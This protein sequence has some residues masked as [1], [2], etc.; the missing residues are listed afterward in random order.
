MITCSVYGSCR[1]SFAVGIRPPSTRSSSSCRRSVT[2]GF[3]ASAYQANVTVRAVVSCPA[4]NVVIDSSRS[5]LSDIAW[6]VSSSRA[7]ISRERRSSGHCASSVPRRCTMSARIERCT[8]SRAARYLR[9]FEVGSHMGSVGPAIG[10]LTNESIV[11][12]ASFIWWIDSIVSVLNIAFRMMEAVTLVI[13]SAIS[14]S[15]PLLAS[16]SQRSKRRAPSRI[17]SSAYAWTPFGV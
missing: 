11:S 9:F 16:A 13:S 6:P 8:I 3:V 1:S 10:S 7:F 5:K 12:T 15:V 4:K 2:F 17:I 14:T